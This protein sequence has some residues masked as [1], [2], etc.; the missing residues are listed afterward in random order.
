MNK[1][2]IKLED[3]IIFGAMCPPEGGWNKITARI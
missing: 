3:I 1:E 2:Y